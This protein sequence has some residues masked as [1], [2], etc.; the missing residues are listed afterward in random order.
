MKKNRN[1]IRLLAVLLALSCG[2]CACS[3]ANPTETQTPSWLEDPEASA[4]VDALGGVS[5]TY[6]GAVSQ[7]SYD[8]AD[9]AAEAYVREEL[10]SQDSDGL[11]LDVT[12]QGQLK[13][14]QIKQLNIPEEY[15]QGM[16]AVECFTVSYSEAEA[17]LE[18]TGVVALSAA[19]GEK[20]ATVY[21]IKYADHFKYF[22]PVVENG[23]TVTKSYYDSIFDSE[24]YQNCTLVYTIDIW[25]E[26]V[27]GCEIYEMS[28]VTY[29]TMRYADDRMYV[30]MTIES[31]TG[32]TSYQL[33]LE[34][35]G[36]GGMDCYINYGNGWLAA[37]ID[38]LGYADV[39]A[40]MPFADQYMDHTY[41]VKTDY[42]CRVD[43]EKMAAYI[44]Q[45]LDLALDDLVEGLD[46]EA[47]GYEEYYVSEGVLSGIRGQVSVSIDYDMF[48]MEETV[49][50][51]MKCT[52]Y[53][54]TVVE[55]P[56]GI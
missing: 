21:V 56:D 39:D 49:I 37:S 19:T 28:A 27:E 32:S 33:Y 5:D 18:R 26:M 30:E 10:L 36:Q 54:T 52:D 15:Q 51:D 41:F 46:V 48:E 3:S 4:F 31:D 13:K 7:E 40:L 1:L 24:K 55:R 35:D 23:D 42:G 45:A 47:T 20:Q 2:L 29:G 22:S 8:D 25:I 6:A 53:G 44:G 9:A 34:N 14:K 17:S 11:I 38:S 12:S 50:T 43:E 16:K